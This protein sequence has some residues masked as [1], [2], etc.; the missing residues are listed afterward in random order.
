MNAVVRLSRSTV[1][2]APIDAVWRLLRDFNSHA[3]W[4]PAIAESRIEAGEAGDTVGS[5]RAFRLADGSMLREQ[6][7]ALSDRDHELTY[8]LIEAPIPLVEY[9]ASMRLRPVTDG[10][11]TLLIWESRF[12][13]PAERAEALS[14]LVGEGIYEAGFVALRARF[15]QPAPRPSSAPLPRPAPPPIEVVPLRA[16]ATAAAAGEIESRAIVVERYGGPEVMSSAMVRVPPPGPGE[17]RLRQAAIGVNF[18]DVYCRTGFL[19]LLKPPGV[20]GMEAAAAVI[21]VGPGV[22]HLRAGDRVAYACEPVGAYAEYR[23]MDATLLVPIPDDI[24]DATAAAIFLKGLA[25][26]FLIHRVHPV[27]AGD[28]VLVHAAAG[29]MGLLFCQWASALGAHVIGTVSSDVKAARVLGAGAERAIVY[30]REDFV[31]GVLQLT[32]GRGVDVVYDGVGSDTFGRSLEAL[33]VRGHLISFGQASGPVGSWDVGAMAAKSATVSRPNFGHYTS[34]PDELRGMAARLFDAL[35]RGI[36]A[37]TI[38]R[39]LPLAEA[40]AAHRRLESR[41]NIGAIVLTP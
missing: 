25:V 14:R 40:P 32:G 27:K 39:R 24:D 18:I 11:R 22:T 5:V 15:G 35:R 26:E 21:D 37:P 6:L 3:T 19:K 20:P 36:I 8:C 4:H 31:T 9:V 13:P 2:D 29:G 7:V 28:T 33:A 16:A 23:T 38:D 17:V 1:I 10:D 41:E 30:T 34:D 12:R